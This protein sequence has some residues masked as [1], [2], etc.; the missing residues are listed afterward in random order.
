MFTTRRFFLSTAASPFAFWLASARRHEAALIRQQLGKDDIAQFRN[1][2]LKLVNSERALAGAS[3]LAIDDLACLVADQH[4]LDMAR[5]KF[6]SHWGKD[7]RK[8]YHRYS[9]AGAVHPVQENVSAASNLESPTSKYIGITLGQM[10]MQMYAEVPPN[11][12][13]R[14]TILTPQHT[15]A[16]FGIALVDRDL[17]LVELYVGKHIHL[18]PYQTQAK[19]KT[20]VQLKGKLLNPG[21]Q[22]SYAEVFFE[23]PPLPPGVDWLREPRAYSLPDKYKTIRLIAP[24]RAVYADGVQGEIEIASQGRFRMPVQLYMNEPGV[25]TVVIWLSDKDGRKKF[26][27]TNICIHVD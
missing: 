7:G 3:S 11:D 5:G 23:P 8:P 17:R 24:Q 6:L 22:I 9:A 27:A 2:L 12:G 14:R 26:G 18:E 4:A 20:T 15:H 25:Y 13:H 16:G 10:H 1:D 19:R 21:Y